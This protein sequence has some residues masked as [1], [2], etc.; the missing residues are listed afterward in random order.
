[1]GDQ[2]GIDSG[3][4]NFGQMIDIH[5]CAILEKFRIIKILD[6]MSSDERQKYCELN[7]FYFLLF[8]DATLAV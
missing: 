5:S 4:H 3:N 6:A 1:M 7:F 2:L 8:L